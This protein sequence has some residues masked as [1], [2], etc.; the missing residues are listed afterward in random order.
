[1]PAQGTNRP[2]KNSKEAAAKAKRNVTIQKRAAANQ[3]TPKKQKK[4][5][6]EGAASM[7]S[8]QLKG[9]DALRGSMRTLLMH[10]T[11]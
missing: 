9:T 11:T 10:R 3:T 7:D 2:T 8:R 4:V 5:K 6:V 1:M